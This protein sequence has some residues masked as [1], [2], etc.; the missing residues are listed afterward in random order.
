MGSKHENLNTLLIKEFAN[1]SNVEAEKL[2]LFAIKGISKSDNTL[3]KEALGIDS[4]GDWAKHWS[5]EAAQAIAQAAEQNKVGKVQNDI[6]IRLI[7]RPKEEISFHKVPIRYNHFEINERHGASQYDIQRVMSFA[8]RK[9]LNIVNVDSLKRR[10]ELQDKADTIERI[11]KLGVHSEEQ[12]FIIPDELAEIV[13]GVLGFEN[14][15]S[16]ASNKHLLPHGVTGVKGFKPQEFAEHYGFPTN[17]SGRN[18]TIAIIAL[19]GNY[20]EKDLL[21]YLSIDAL[22]NP[23]SIVPVDGGTAGSDSQADTELMMDIQL[24]LATA[25]DAKIV[26]YLAPKTTTGFIDAVNTAVH[27][28]LYAPGIISI[29]WGQSEDSWPSYARKEMD[30]VFKV[31]AK[32]GI[33]I[34]AASGD[35]G[36]SDGIKDHKAHVDFPASSPHVTACGGTTLNLDAEESKEIVWD[37]DLKE[38]GSGGGVSNFFSMPAWQRSMNVPRRKSGH[39]GRGIPDIAANADPRTGYFIQ[40]NGKKL[41]GGGTSA[42]APLMAGFVARLNEARGTLGNI[43]FLNPHLYELKQSE[44]FSDITIGNNGKYLASAGWDAC[45]GLGSPLGK[46]LMEALTNHPTHALLPASLHKKKTAQDTSEGGELEARVVVTQGVGNAAKDLK[47]LNEFMRWLVKPDAK[48]VLS[49]VEYASLSKDTISFQHSL[50]NL[51]TDLLDAENDWHNL[52]K[53]NNTQAIEAS[54]KSLKNHLHIAVKESETVRSAASRLHTTAQ[55]VKDSLPS[56]KAD[57]QRKANQAKINRDVA[58]TKIAQANADM[59]SAKD[60]LEGF[61][62]VKNSFLTG[63]TLTI[64]NPVQDNYNKY[65][66]ARN[67]ANLEYA[68]YQME[69]QLYQDELSKVQH[70]ETMLDHISPMVSS[71]TDLQSLLA[72]VNAGI[73]AAEKDENKAENTTRLK[74]FWRNRL[75]KEMDVLAEWAEVLKQETNSLEHILVSLGSEVVGGVTKLAKATESFLGSFLKPR[76]ATAPAT[77]NWLEIYKDSYIRSLNLPTPPKSEIEKVN[78]LLVYR[79]EDEDSTHGFLLCVHDLNKIVPD[80]QRDPWIIACDVLRIDEDLVLNGLTYIFARRI[81]IIG[82]SQIVLDLAEED[83]DGRDFLLY[84][85]EI[86]DTNDNDCALI[87]NKILPDADD[88]I[89][90]KIELDTRLNTFDATRILWEAADEANIIDAGPLDESFLYEGTPLR[91]LLTS[92]FQMA[93]FI[94]EEYKELVKKQSRWIAAMASYNPGTRPMALQ[95]MSYANRITAQL[96]LKDGA[97]L[98]PS[99]DASLYQDDLKA[100]G[101]LLTTQQMNW[102]LLNLQ[103]N[104]EKSF[105]DLAIDAF[106]DKDDQAKLSNKLVEKAKTERDNALEAWRQA[107]TEMNLRKDLYGAAETRFNAGVKIWKRKE[108][109]KTS[110]SLALNTITL[111]AQVGVIIAEIVVAPPAGAASAA[112]LAGSAVQAGT[113]TVTLAAGVISGVSSGS[114]RSSSQ[115]IGAAGASATVTLTPVPKE[116]PTPPTKFDKLKAAGGKFADKQVGLKNSAK[117]IVA[118]V[119]RIIEISKHADAL[120]AGAATVT[121]ELDDM[122]SKAGTAEL[123]G[124]NVVTGGKQFWDHFELNV[125]SLFE[126]GMPEYKDIDGGEDYR[127]TFKHLILTARNVCETRLALATAAGK[128]AE[129]KLQLQTAKSIQERAKKRAEALAENVKWDEGIAQMMFQRVVNTKRA[130]YL[131]CEE[132]RRALQYFTL[133]PDSN[134]PKLPD[135]RGG[136]DSI[137]LAVNTLTSKTFQYGSFPNQIYPQKMAGT[138]YEVSNPLI[139]QEFPNTDTFRYLINFDISPKSSNWDAYTRIRFTEVSPILMDASGN[140]IEIGS[141]TTFRVSTSGEYKDRVTGNDVQNFVSDPLKLVIQST[142]KGTVPEGFQGK[143]FK[144]TPFSSWTILI[145]KLSEKLPEGTKL[146]LKFDGEVSPK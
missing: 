93:I 3:L 47:E 113:T 16:V 114:G 107:N 75:G 117:G 28:K 34:L 92:L 109:I 112:S 22:P 19:G 138:I 98:V 133:L 145:E 143:Y 2:P 72:N 146:V 76:V 51:S 134:L 78:N 123:T 132:Y 116:T 13:E 33:T 61:N 15:F 58:A 124:M 129:A 44:T 9:G 59:E 25:P 89:I 65:E 120:L 115:S 30:R 62:R 52:V 105:R 142:I 1:S 86:K 50:A 104:V 131:L 71:V 79:M 26:V 60:E 41:I 68:K 88:L 8:K 95:A 126:N 56:K 102:R 100:W 4:I 7:L 84:T 12:E 125:D 128:L 74:Q 20:S 67:A 23:V 103:T 127:L 43:G 14:N 119:E 101:D 11:F 108:T 77:T 99:L 144:P 111:I 49:I 82:D 37:N 87:V 140:K 46:K 39:K 31:A 32:L 48:D 106:K 27:D 110:V 45:T 42:V 57:H 63:V 80:T 69:Y 6:T 29:S 96:A 118:D 10:I 136:A 54:C 18:Q 73:K 36:S 64:Y 137:Q 70:C 53:A 21:E 139:L 141:D 81:E 35:N 97:I 38:L 130:I 85:Q 91:L 66:N 5:V 90:R 24:A 83:I 17:Y 40:V 55:S 121:E 122:A 94:E 135:L